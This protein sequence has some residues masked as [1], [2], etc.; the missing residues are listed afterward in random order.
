[1]NL[2]AYLAPFRPRIFSALGGYTRERF[3][4]DL[5]A[6]MT[7]GMVALPLAMA[8]AIASGLSPQAG[9]WTAI[10][11]GGLIALLGGSAV[12]IGGPAGAFIVIVYGIVEQYGLPNLLIST[13]C[14][15]V[16]LFLLGFLKMGTLVRYVPVSIVVGFTN[17]IAVLIALSQLKDLLGLQ[18]AR[19]PADFFSQ[20]KALAAHMD[21]FNASALGLGAACFLGLVLWPKLFVSRSLGTN[22]FTARLISRMQAV[23]GVQLLR[24]TRAVSRVP[25][26]IVALITLTVFAWLLHLP[27]DT[28]G[29][30]FGGIPQALPHFALPAFSWDTVRL[31]LPPTL[32][33]AM[34]GAVESLLCARV[35]D[36]LSG[37]PKHDPN[38]ELMAQGIANF[39]VP[40]FGGMPATGTMA[41]TVTNLRAGATS[42]VAGLTHALTLMLVVLVAAPL[43]MHVPLAVLAG[44]LVHVAWNM[45]EWREFA[46]LRQ[47]SSHYRL[48]MLGTFLLTVV[49]DLTVALQVGLLLACVL[50][51]RRMSSLFQVVETERTADSV[52]FQ[53]YGSLFFG[54]VAKIDPV[55]SVVES[56][57]G[58]LLVRLDAQS[59]QSLDASGLDVLVQL[60]K[61]V[62]LRGGRLVISGLNAQPRAVMARAGFLAKVNEL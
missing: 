37:L 20:I 1:M 35:A 50:F 31:L 2:P 27:V 34:L 3:A 10:I 58:A 52:H 60:H 25:G 13:A 15:G 19:M 43:A 55:L 42:P 21:S 16:L 56:A 7:V 22:G 40:F 23:E 41:R 9:I 4:K 12:Q 49:F 38:Q 24:A 57:P 5:G 28:I 39:V 8:F 26:P 45:G 46:R 29:S 44:F 59:L 32:T 61:A 33:I 53:L 51:V 54:A 48:L 30:R 18:I 36:Q 6:G 17:G 11:A 47:Y 62:V 14:A